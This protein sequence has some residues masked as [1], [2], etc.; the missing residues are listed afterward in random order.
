[1]VNR[2]NGEV[3]TSDSAIIVRRTCEEDW[4]EYRALRLE[5]LADTPLAF[6]ETL[7]TAQRRTDVEWRMRAARGEAREQTLMVAIDRATGA[8]VGTMGALIAFGPDVAGPLL[9][10]VYV[11]P[12]HR[13]RT[14]GVADALLSA[15]EAWA[16]EH[17][18]HLLLN[19]H[20]HNPRAIAFYERHGYAHTGRQQ[21]YILDAAQQEL[22]MVKA[23]H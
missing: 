11:S 18:S 23:L 4:R 19:V 7:A 6:G 14:R 16:A 15:I 17:G 20:E 12:T 13:G 1:M 21:P 8:W 5:M 22:E 9:V 10:G 3:S 2:L